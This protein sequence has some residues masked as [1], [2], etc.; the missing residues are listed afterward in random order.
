MTQ[1]PIA[2]R[3]PAQRLQDLVAAILMADGMSRSHAFEVA[4]VLVWADLRGVPGHG[5]KR[6]ER[7]LAFI[8]RGDLD[9]RA[10]PELT[11]LMPAAFL[12]AANRSAGAVAMSMATREAM[13][14]ASRIGAAFGVVRQTTHTGAIGY[15]VEQMAAAG[16]IGVA[17]AAGPLNM[18]YHGA[19]V[20]SLSTSPLAIAV[21]GPDGPL[22]LDMAT[23]AMS[24]GKLKG[25]AERGE[26]LPPGVALDEDGRPALEAARAVLPLPLGG[27][28]GSGLAFMIECLTSLL[29][30][31]PIATPALTGTG[32]RRH[33]QNAFVLAVSVETFRSAG[34][35]GAD[36]G[37]FVEAIKALP[38]APSATEIRPP[39]Q[40][41]REAFSRNLGEGVALAA[42]TRR[43][44]GAAAAAR[45]IDDVPWPTEA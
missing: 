12:C 30:G 40:R 22:V 6:L 34:A 44:L 36:V 9:P 32:R 26:A 2:S 7:Y 39:G 14:T 16:F 1:G 4:E 41:G 13:A 23:S 45:G 35:F 42:G 10:R 19:S 8:A 43:Q 24:I 37:A 38:L 17:A 15:F 20:P 31:A 28:K 3:I 33:M 18:A 27:A 11:P 29:A 25:M 21:P 5:C